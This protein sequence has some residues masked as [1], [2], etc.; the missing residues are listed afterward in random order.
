MVI[1]TGPAENIDDSR[2]LSGPDFDGTVAAAFDI[3]RRGFSQSPIHRKSIVT[4]V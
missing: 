3:G 4:A 1:G 2:C